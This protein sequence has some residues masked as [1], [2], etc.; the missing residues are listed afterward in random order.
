M[1]I[2]MRMVQ[3]RQSQVYLFAKADVSCRG[4]YYRIPLFV[5]CIDITYSSS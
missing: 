4:D 1:L 2:Y 3:V 5:C